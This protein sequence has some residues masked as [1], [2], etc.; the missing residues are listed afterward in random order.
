MDHY[1][2]LQVAPNAAMQE[3]KK[4][5]WQLCRIYHPDVTQLPKEDAERAMRR[6]NEAYR[7]LSNEELRRAYDEELLPVKQAGEAVQEERQVY[8]YSAQSFMEFQIAC[9][10]LRGFCDRIISECQDEIRPETV[11]KKEN[12]KKAD[13]LYERF[14]RRFPALYKDVTEMPYTKEST[15]ECVGMAFYELALAYAYSRAFKKSRGCMEQAIIYWEHVNK[16]EVNAL[17][18]EYE[19]IVA[20][21]KENQGWT[22]ELAVGY[23]TAGAAVLLVVWGLFQWLR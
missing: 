12:R 7:V 15:Q 16:S 2:V 13:L 5:Y 8:T 6:I 1:R 21:E 11:N 20:M 22:A 14:L 18:E 17:R 4:S 9:E 19:R 3:I 23:I 10:R